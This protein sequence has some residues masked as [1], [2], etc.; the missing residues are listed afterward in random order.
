MSQIY[1]DP[2]FRDVK[3]KYDYSEVVLNGSSASF[4]RSQLVLPESLTSKDKGNRII[5]FYLP[6]FHRVAENDLHWGKGFTE[7]T[8]LTRAQPLFMGHVQPRLPGDLGFYDLSIT[9]NIREQITIASR[10]GLSAFCFYYY[11]FAR[12]T[13][14]DLPL[15][16]FAAL[17]DQ[18]LGF[19][20][21]WANESWT[22]SWDGGSREVLIEQ[23]HSFEFDKGFIHEIVDYLK[24]PNYQTISGRKLLLIYRVELLGNDLAKTLDYWREV[25]QAEGVGDLAIFATSAFLP[26]KP[27][28]V[29]RLLMHVDGLVQF[30][31]HLS[32]S[33]Q[34]GIEKDLLFCKEF[35]GRLSFYD[36]AVAH[37]KTQYYGARVVIPTVFPSWDNTP[38]RREQAS[39][40]LNCSPDSFER[41]LLFALSQSEG[42]PENDGIVFVNAWNEW[43]EGAVLEPC[44]WFG[45]AYLNR[46][47][48]VLASVLNSNL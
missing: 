14:L 31:P 1:I 44:R 3:N 47:S 24:K 20:I 13:I 42:R 27:E 48:R 30:P 29:D 8:N 34:I 33:H 4:E 6:Q 32:F 22:R 12:K 5:A 43:A 41:E 15:K 35:S 40:F 16:K 2:A 39:V 7:W 9:D 46:C 18:R 25:A 19:C 28:A 23:Q 37:L 38:R 17:E 45:Y 36:Q 26:S 11:R 21:C 10:A